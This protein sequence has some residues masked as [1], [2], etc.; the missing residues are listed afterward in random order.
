MAQKKKGINISGALLGGAVI[1]NA[2]GKGMAKGL[3]RIMNT[4]ISGTGKIKTKGRKKK[5]ILG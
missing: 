5:G 3:N 2:I 4:Q 1:G